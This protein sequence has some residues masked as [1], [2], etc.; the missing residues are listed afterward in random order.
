MA[1]KGV[2]HEEGPERAPLL[3][4]VDKREIEYQQGLE[5]FRDKLSFR[6]N[7]RELEAGPLFDALFD[8]PEQRSHLKE[9]Y[10]A[11][12]ISQLANDLNSLPVDDKEKL[13]DLIVERAAPVL[14]RYFFESE[15]AARAKQVEDRINP[16]REEF[17]AGQID[18][19][20]TS[21]PWEFTIGAGTAG[22]VKVMVADNIMELNWPENS[23]WGVQAVK[24]SLK[25]VAK[26]LKDR[27]EVKAVVGVSWMMAHDVTS[28]IGFEKFPDLRIDADTRD[29]SVMMAIAG[30]TGKPYRPG[31]EPKP[32]DVMVGAMSR[33]EFLRRFT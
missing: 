9:V 21:S 11:Q 20:I 7:N 33:E 2:E 24:E 27:P 15:V 29:G 6:L 12:E 14:R 3:S 18:G 5:K 17:K 16:P 28:A 8:T 1:P 25:E 30:R 10:G 19:Y 31:K 22:E 4:E 26:L 13:A 32:A 23:Q